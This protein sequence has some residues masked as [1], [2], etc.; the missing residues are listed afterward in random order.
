LVREGYIEQHMATDDRRKRLL[1]L[2]VKGVELE[3]ALTAQQ[4]ERIQGAYK[5][6]GAKAVQG[7]KDV[8]EGIMDSNDR[9]RF[10]RGD[11]NGVD[12]VS[13]PTVLASPRDG[14]S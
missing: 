11:D 14:G 9:W 7:F 8:M 10:R 4:R 3:R 5:A 1:R 13:P 2:T 6:A 12:L